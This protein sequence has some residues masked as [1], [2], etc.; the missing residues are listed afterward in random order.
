MDRTYRCGVGAF[1]LGYNDGL[2]EL[3]G[4]VLLVAFLQRGEGITRARFGLAVHDGAV[5]Q[6]HALPAIIAIHGVVTADE[7][8]DLSDL[9]L[10][11]LLL[12]LADEIAAA[13]RRRVAA[14]HEAMDEDFLDFLLLGHF[15]QREKMLDVRVHAAIAEQAEEVELALAAALHRLLKQRNILQ[16]LVGDEQVD[17]GHVH[18]DDAAGADVEVADL[19][20]AHLAFRQAHERA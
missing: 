16:L 13:V 7:S 5:G 12:Q 17:A 1:A 4:Y 20:V 8:G 2:D 11:H 18:V 3:V 19:A 14:V 6:L 10:A 15:E 9:Q